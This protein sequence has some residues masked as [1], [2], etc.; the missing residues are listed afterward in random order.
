[1]RKG[2][3]Y[4]MLQNTG[5]KLHFHVMGSVFTLPWAERGTICIFI[6]RT[7]IQLAW[8]KF[9]S[10]WLSWCCCPVEIVFLIGVCTPVLNRHICSLILQARIA[11]ALIFCLFLTLCHVASESGSASE[12]LTFVFGVFTWAPALTWCEGTSARNRRFCPGVQGR[13]FSCSSGPLWLKKSLQIWTSGQTKR[14]IENCQCQ[15]KNRVL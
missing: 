5:I 10:A 8:V 11:Y 2:S 4:A 1:M 14:F 7:H 13:C 3:H 15:G 6:Q 9:V 12:I